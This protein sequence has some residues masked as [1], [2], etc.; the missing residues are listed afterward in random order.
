MLNVAYVRLF[1]SEPHCKIVT[2]DTRLRNG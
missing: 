1:D 2:L